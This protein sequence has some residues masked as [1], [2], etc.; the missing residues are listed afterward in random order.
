MF[1]IASSIG[2]VTYDY[3]YA[4]IEGKGNYF[5]V[6]HRPMILQSALDEIKQEVDANKEKK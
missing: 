1:G 2:I 6:V 4:D 5:N 3:L